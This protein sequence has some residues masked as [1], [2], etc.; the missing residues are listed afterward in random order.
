MKNKIFAVILIAA[1]VFSATAAKKPKPV[2]PITVK[3]T[4]DK[5]TIA[6]ARGHNITSDKFALSK[7]AWYIVKIAYTGPA[8]STCQ[9]SLATQAM[10]TAKDTIGGLLTNWMGPSTTELIKHKGKMKSEDYMIYVDDAEG[11]WT[12]EI[13]KNP[14]PAPV[15]PAT[16]FSGT[17][18]KLTPFFHLKKGPAKFVMNHKAGKGAFAPR[19]WV[20]LFNA[21]TGSYVSELC[22]NAT[23]PTLKKTEDIPAAG[24]YV[25]QVEGGNSWDVSFT[26]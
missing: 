14:K 18:N 8:V 13:T 3:Q 19:L 23:E 11:P 26:Q 20:I 25:L 7:D 4:A 24:N 17:T 12:V 22:H 2:D 6:G 21:D 5:I 15:S 1:A 16:T 10:V 9:L